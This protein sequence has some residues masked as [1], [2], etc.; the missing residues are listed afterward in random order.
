MEFAL[1]DPEEVLSNN[2]INDRRCGEEKGE[3][4]VGP[5]I[6]KSEWRLRAIDRFSD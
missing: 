5:C 6:G 2:L 1:L 3:K 4:V